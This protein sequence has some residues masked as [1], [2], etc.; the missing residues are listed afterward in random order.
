MSTYSL[1]L[2]S[3][4]NRRLTISEMD[5]NFLY[6][7]K[8]TQEIAT[9]ITGPTGPSGGGTGSSYDQDLNTFNDVLFDSVTTEYIYGQE[10]AILLVPDNSVPWQ[11]AVFY[12]TN[13]VIDENHIHIAPAAPW[14]DLFL[15]PDESY[16]AIKSTGDIEINP[17]SGTVSVKG[18]L[19]LFSKLNGS[20][21]LLSSDD[22]T[23]IQAIGVDD[24]L[25]NYI[26]GGNDTGKNIVSK[27]SNG[28]IIWSQEIV[29]VGLSPSTVIEFNSVVYD[30]DVIYVTGTFGVEG[31]GN[32]TIF[33]IN[34]NTGAILNSWSYTDPNGFTL[35]DIHSKN[36]NPIVVGLKSNEYIN[37]STF[38]TTLIG[39]TV[40]SLITDKSYFSLIEQYPTNSQ[41]WEINGTG[42]SNWTQINTN[43]TNKLYNLT[44][45][46]IS[47]T[48]SN[49]L[50][51]VVYDPNT[52]TYTGVEVTNQGSGYLAGEQILV[53]GSL[54]DGVDGVTYSANI[55]NY[56]GESLYFET[57][58]YPDFDQLIDNGFR[59]S[60]TGIT[61]YGTVSNLQNTGSLWRVDIGQNV[62]LD[63]NATILFD[64]NG[65]NDLSFQVGYVENDTIAYF[66]S[67]SGSLGT[68][69]IIIDVSQP[70]D[71]TQPGEW[72]LRT[73]TFNQGLVWTKDWIKSIGKTGY[74]VARCV[75]TDSNNDIYV[76]LEYTTIGTKRLMVIKL[77]SDGN[78]IWSKHF[79]D[80]TNYNII[81][82]INVDS[83][84]NILI[85]ASNDDGYLVVTKANNDGT[86]IWQKI[87]NTN[88]WD[89]YPIST[90]DKDDNLIISTSYGF[91]NSAD[92]AIIK[93]DGSNGNIIFG[94]SIGTDNEDEYD[95]WFSAARSL[96]TMDNM[97]YKSGYRYNDNN[98]D[99]IIITLNINGDG[100]GEYDGWNYRNFEVIT[101][102]SDSTSSNANPHIID[103]TL[104]TIGELNFDVNDM[105]N[106]F[107]LSQ[108]NIN[109][110]NSAINI[111][112]ITFTDGSVLK[113]SLIKQ[114]LQTDNSDYTLQLSDINGH[115]F[116]N[117]GNGYGINIPTNDSVPFKIGSAITIVSG[118]SPI[119]F[120]L[121]N[122]GVTEVWGAGYGQTSNYWYIPD[123]SMATLLKIGIDKWM[124]SGAGLN[125]D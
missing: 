118:Y 40:S 123:H 18:D 37:S 14:T 110:N 72:S 99:G 97:L 38:S 66:Q 1:N 76:G 45:I 67:V 56:T 62:T 116:R 102:N 64:N 106:I 49:L 120:H 96:V 10:G 2:R 24:S 74:E 82:S 46:N 70:V 43:N 51:N 124:L 115:I 98:S 93:I 77:D 32:F 17:L 23:W 68:D 3:E 31:Q 79:D 55:F 88:N 86:I 9:G 101:D 95:Y 42:F 80:D 5:G 119:Y 27:I 113:S 7:E 103:I 111:E 75:T 6:L 12:A 105:T 15:G 21:S 44:T 109:K 121:E 122:S 90:V 117:D 13:N 11:S 73:S 107:T 22:Y 100:I 50:V 84:D 63:D 69:R 65:G 25:N 4:L 19:N 125:I 20:I 33:E 71:F 92:Y 58:S 87:T 16:V 85:S 36:N 48:G 112:S 8:L 39:S 26:V 104:D 94:R 53:K 89:Q 83:D 78:E 34:T 81:S 29:I 28:E 108:I 52:N 91:N 60:G 57:S 114:N 54:L 61:G 41:T 59:V 35:H 30:N 47:G